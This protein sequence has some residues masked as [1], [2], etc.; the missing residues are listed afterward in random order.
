M[1]VYQ[2]VPTC[3]YCSR[4]D[5]LLFQLL[6]QTNVSMF[7]AI[8]APFTS[9]GR[10]G[11]LFSPVTGSWMAD[12]SLSRAQLSKLLSRLVVVSSN[13]ALIRARHEAIYLPGS[14][15]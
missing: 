2:S 12:L 13:G 9:S 1:G 4:F 10:G 6:G 8:D 11:R 15:T 5:F 3:Q 14:D 7:R